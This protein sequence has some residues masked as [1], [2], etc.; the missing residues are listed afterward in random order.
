MRVGGAGVEDGVED[1]GQVQVTS[2]AHNLT[3]RPI[4][5]SGINNNNKLNIS[6]SKRTFSNIDIVHNAFIVIVLCRLDDK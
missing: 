2:L 4:I 6:G 1:A 5:A 3:I